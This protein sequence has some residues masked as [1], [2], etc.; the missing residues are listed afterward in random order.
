MNVETDFDLIG[1]G[2]LTWVMERRKRSG[3]GGREYT[4]GAPLDCM[5]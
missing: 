4:T 1:Q 2:N 3:D 5:L